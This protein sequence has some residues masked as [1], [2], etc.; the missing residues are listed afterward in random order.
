MFKDKGDPLSMY[1]GDGP[2]VPG[3]RKRDAPPPPAAFDPKAWLASAFASLG[4]RARSALKAL[5]ALSM[6][7]GVF[8]AVPFIAP[9]ART[10]VRAINWALRL[11]GAGPRARAAK[12]VAVRTAS[13]RADPANAA[14]GEHELR[15]LARFG[16]E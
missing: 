2:T 1:D 16:P 5:A 9:A 12:R 4:A 14:L 15:A 6:M 11:D 10:G 13:L 8:I 7:A 3:A